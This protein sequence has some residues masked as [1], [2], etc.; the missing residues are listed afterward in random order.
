MNKFAS[1]FAILTWFTATAAHSQQTRE[2]EF[3]GDSMSVRQVDG[4]TIR[5]MLRP[6]LIDGDTRLTADHGV[7]EG[8]GYVRF[9]GNVVIFKRE[10][11]IRAERV[12][13]H[14]ETK[15]GVAEGNVTMSNSEV[16]LSAPHAIHYSDEDRTEFEAGVRYSDSLTVLIARRATYLSE[17]DEVFFWGNV[18]LNQEGLKLFADSLTYL[19]D[20]EISRAWGRISLEQVS[21]SSSIHISGNFLYHNMVTDSMYVSGSVRMAMI[22]KISSDTVYVFSDQIFI[23]G[24][25][26]KESVTAVD[27]VVVSAPAYELMGDSLKWV[28]DRNDKSSQVYGSPMAWLN[29]TQV[30][31][32]SL[33]FSSYANRPDS[34]FGMGFGNVFVASMDSTSG[35]IQQLRSQFLEAVI[36]HD[37]LR[38]LRIEH[39]AE[40]LFYTRDSVD[41][42]LTALRA[43]ADAGL[44]IFE[45]GVLVDVRF[46]EGIEGTYY[47]ENLLDQLYNLADYIWVPQLRPDRKE[48]AR[49]FW[50]ENAV[51][52]KST[53]E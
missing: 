1:L 49:L 47:A 53:K 12:R 16:V 45:N 8:N 44:F 29:E 50:T 26:G 15:V 13:Y 14:K 19:R 38:S 7:D 36:V 27:S 37:S 2:V 46:Y 30:S 20:E 18:R 22:D 23:H 42:S 43:S 11:T 39:N 52:T 34:V 41:D 21:D 3:Y 32:D 4:R 25:V 51:W 24:G 31:A 48:M 5:E 40:A 35:R 6:I 33:Y 17:N 28:Q 10:D 9:W